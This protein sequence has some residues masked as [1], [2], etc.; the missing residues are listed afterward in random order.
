MRDVHQR[1]LT[2]FET[3]L[4]A[5]TSLRPLKAGRSPSLN[6]SKRSAGRCGVTPISEE[7][8]RADFERLLGTRRLNLGVVTGLSGLGGVST[9]G[10]ADHILRHEFFYGGQG[11]ILFHEMGLVLGYNHDS[12]M[13]YPKDGKGFE[14]VCEVDFDMDGCVDSENL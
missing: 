11:G 14:P 4:G 6:A 3:E 7:T 8:K 12:S 2:L 5:T 9:H 10:V 13:T 1:S